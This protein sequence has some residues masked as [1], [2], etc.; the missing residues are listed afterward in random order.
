MESFGGT[1][2][3]V[4]A[5]ALSGFDTQLGAELRRWITAEPGEA[6]GG[7]TLA[8]LVTAR[9]RTVG[10]RQ[11]WEPLLGALSEIE[12]RHGDHLRDHDPFT[13]AFLDSVLAHHRG[14]LDNDTY[15]ALPL[16]RLAAAD[17]RSGLDPA[18]L[19]GLLLA[20]LLRH[21]QF[22]EPA[23]GMDVHARAER[24]DLAAAFIAQTDPT[25]GA[26]VPS[27]PGTAAGEWLTLTAMPMSTGHD[28]YLLIRVLQAYALV[29]AMMTGLVADATAAVRTGQ[30]DLA[31]VLVRRADHVFRRA[32]TLSQLLEGMRDVGQIT[33]WVD[34]A[35]PPAYRDFERARADLAGAV[36]LAG[37]GELAGAG[38]PAG[39]GELAGAGA[40]EPHGDLATATAALDTSRE[41]WTAVQDELAARFEAPAPAA[42]APPRSAQKPLMDRGRVPLPARVASPIQLRALAPA[43]VRAQVTP[44][45]QYVRRCANNRE[46]ASDTLRLAFGG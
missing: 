25:L 30:P 6:P 34:L 44:A 12:C 15:L 2:V 27:P 4:P 39:T 36:E 46:V 40:D 29:F 45:A 21:E 31:A 38:G 20:D 24:A 10:R 43:A 22:S 11:L 5:S 35:R 41:A 42:P 13:H 19:S 3:D 9:I 14:R 32:A 26:A 7:F 33:S 1:A 23:S 17:R 18:R 37:T 28:E 16:L 8:W